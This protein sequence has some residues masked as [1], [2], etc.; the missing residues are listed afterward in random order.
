MEHVTALFT[1]CCLGV[2]ILGMFCVLIVAG[3]WLVKVAMEYL[4]VWHIYML[5]I[6]IRL[7]GKGYADQQFWWAIQER[8][9]KGRFFANMVANHAHQHAPHEDSDNG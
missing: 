9:S 3:A 8:A 1:Y 5:A 2:G 6:S 7:H 4:K